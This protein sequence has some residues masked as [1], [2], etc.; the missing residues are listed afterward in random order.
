MTDA[1]LEDCSRLLQKLK[2]LRMWQNLVKALACP[3]A[4][5]YVLAAQRLVLISECCRTLNLPSTVSYIDSVRASLRLSFAKAVCL[6]SRRF[7]CG[8]HVFRY[9]DEMP[10]PHLLAASFWS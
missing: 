1:Y 5:H 2:R 6:T 3:A 9:A 7:V 10:K 4:I 8:T